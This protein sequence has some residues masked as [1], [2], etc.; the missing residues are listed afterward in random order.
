[1]LT[2]IY[3]SEQHTE[4]NCLHLTVFL[5]FVV[6]VEIL[7]SNVEFRATGAYSKWNG[8]QTH[9]NARKFVV[10]YKKKI[11]RRKSTKTEMT[12]AKELKKISVF[13]PSILC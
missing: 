2:E 4:L 12:V 9:T 11:V 8:T 5:S 6:V 1:M 13:S 10:I 3:D 7:L